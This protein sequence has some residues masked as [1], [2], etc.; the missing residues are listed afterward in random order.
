M[1]KPHPQLL[2]TTRKKV[3]TVALTTTTDICSN[4]SAKEVLSS[5]FLWM[6]TRTRDLNNH[7]NTPFF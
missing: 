7:L 3:P 2:V 6:R 4:S 5:Q 1:F